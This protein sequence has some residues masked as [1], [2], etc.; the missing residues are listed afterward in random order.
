[1]K[2]ISISIKGYESQDKVPIVFQGLGKYYLR[3]TS[4]Y[5]KYVEELEDGSIVEN[6]IK[7]CDD[8]I[9]IFKKG[10]INTKMHFYKDKNTIINY[11]TSLIDLKFDLLTEDIIYS[12]NN[13]GFEINIIY[14]LYVDEEIISSN[15]INLVVVFQ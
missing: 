5:I 3:S 10:A 7:I 1:M 11:S 13:N 15:K 9:I 14:N 2:E 12:Q 4:E 8:G 6:L